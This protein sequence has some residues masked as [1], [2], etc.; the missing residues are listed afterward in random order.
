LNQLVDFSKRI[1]KIK[2]ISPESIRVSIG[3]V[4]KLAFKSTIK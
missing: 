3:F 2:A 4:F 1:N